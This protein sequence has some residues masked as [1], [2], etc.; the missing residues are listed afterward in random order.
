MTRQL[1]F[2]ARLVVG[3]ACLWAVSAEAAPITALFNT[4]VD[5][6]NALLPIGS[7]DPHYT[8]V[9][10]PNLTGPTAYV[11]VP[12]P[13]WIANGP[14]SQWISIQPNSALDGPIAAGTYDYRTTFNL[15]GFDPSTAVITGGWSTD[16][17]GTNI[18]INGISTGFTTSVTQFSIGFAPFTISTGFVAG[19][20]TLDFVLFEDGGITGL[21][22]ELSGTANVAAV[23]EASSILLLGSGL[24][25]LA[26]WR[27]TR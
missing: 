2:L 24:A 26:F 21:R 4:G 3:M 11:T 19:I 17:N 20:N 5:N 13:A 10:N 9:T 15:T 22:V 18:L 1:K 14:S 16:N 8:V 12:H 25:G 23:P 27:R 7:V 6:S